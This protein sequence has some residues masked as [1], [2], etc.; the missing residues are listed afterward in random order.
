MKALSLV[1]TAFLLQFLIVR[2]AAMAQSPSAPLVVVRPA[3]D[4]EPAI[5][6]P[7]GPPAETVWTKACSRFPSIRFTRP[8]CFGRFSK[9][10]KS[11]ADWKQG[12]ARTR[13]EK[14]VQPQSQCV[15]QFVNHILCKKCEDCEPRIK[16]I[17][18]IGT[19]ELSSNWQLA[20]DNW[21]LATDN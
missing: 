7:S 15:I 17:A 6:Q 1:L 18:R 16:R 11:T 5:P 10:S 12:I 3:A 4:G 14:T 21:Q 9:G 8:K 19:A 2:A 20:T 13:V